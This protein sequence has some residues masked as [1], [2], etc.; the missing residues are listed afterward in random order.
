MYLYSTFKNNT[1]L[2]KCFPVKESILKIKNIVKGNEIKI[3]VYISKQ[4][5]VRL[6]KSKALNIT[7]YICR[8]CSLA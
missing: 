3:V 2:T 5:L 7:G 1:S 4:A 8:M 6:K